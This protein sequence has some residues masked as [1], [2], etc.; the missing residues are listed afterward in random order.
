MRVPGNFANLRAD[1]GRMQTLLDR[2]RHA[3]L[4]ALAALAALMPLAA[5]AQPVRADHVEAELVAATDAVVAGQPLRVGLRLNHDPHWHTYWRV[6]GD[7]GLPTQIA[8]TLPPGWTAAPID[9]PVPKRLPIGPLMNFGYEDEVLLLVQLTPPAGALPGARVD[10]AARAD[11]LVC[12]DV[13]IP[14][15]ADLKLALPVAAQARPGPH[16]ALFERMQARVPGALRADK[17]S[18]TLDADRIRLAFTATPTPK[19]V[20]FFPLEEARIE[21][22][23]PQVLQAD[24]GASALL[25]RA[26]QPVSPQFRTLKGVLVV[27]GGPG[28][29]AGWAGTVEVALTPGTVAAAP[30]GGLGA[31]ASAGG[32]TAIGFWGALVGALIGG[33]ILNLMPCVFPVLSLKLL[34]LMQHQREAGAAAGRPLR[35]HGLAFA[36]GVVLSFL[37]LAGLL[38]AL[39]AGGE[40]LGWGFQLQTPWVVAALAVLFVAIGLN[41]LG[42]F[43]FAFGGRLASSAVA[44]RLQSDTL[45]GSFW[46]GVLAVVVAAPCTAPFMGAALG[47]AVSQPAAVALLIFAMLG[48]GMAIPYLLLTIFPALLARLPRPGAWMERF[49]QAMAFPM[50][51]TA[52]WLLWVLALQVD[53]NG[54]GLVLAALVL[55]GLGAWAAGL[56]QRGARGFRW[57]ALLAAGLALYAVFAATRAPLQA[58]AVADSGASASASQRAWEPWSAQRVAQ[59]QAQGTPVFIDFTAAWCVTCQANKQLVLNRASVEQAFDLAGVVRLRADWTR[60][61][62][63]ITRELARYNRNG[64]PL[65]VLIDRKGRAQVLPE[66]LTESALTQALAQL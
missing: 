40:Q 5:G 56:A 16:A 51:A 22:A 14:G 7:S 19:Q 36:A 23:A 46:T 11:W 10:L 32:A 28:E 43:E 45:A 62:D 6:P 39:R 9:W 41:L 31:A 25:L 13:C 54:I 2:L 21:A 59:L 66:V 8:W 50:F 38:L 1:Q 30:A 60:R 26:A 18:A 57:V 27:D 64:V 52:V 29:G 34:S 48:V 42:A 20:E 63:D 3:A 65:Y 17:V 44:Q 58:A 24:G 4:T 47:Y 53:A 35:A 15:G 12:K 37:L 33:L 49:K 55:V 61:D